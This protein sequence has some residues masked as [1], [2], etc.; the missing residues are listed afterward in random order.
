MAGLILTFPSRTRSIRGPATM[1]LYTRVRESSSMP[2]FFFH[3]PFGEISK[4]FSFFKSFHSHYGEIKYTEGCAAISPHWKQRVSKNKEQMDRRKMRR[5]IAGK[6]ADGSREKL[7]WKKVFP[8]PFSKNFYSQS[9]IPRSA[10]W[11][12]DSLKICKNLYRENKN[13]FSLICEQKVLEKGDGVRGAQSALYSGGSTAL[14]RVCRRKT[15]FF[16]SFFLFPG[17]TL[18]L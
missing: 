13:F 7:F 10:E 16:K 17:I 8:A 11:G 1:V 3:E 4:R 18:L 5:W 14:S 9:L 2:D 12:F 15:T 6:S